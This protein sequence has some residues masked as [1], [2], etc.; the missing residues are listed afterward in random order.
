MRAGGEGRRAF[1]G[2]VAD[3]GVR[4]WRTTG[5]GG[6][7]GE[8]DFFGWEKKSLALGLLLWLFVGLSWL[9]SKSLNLGGGALCLVD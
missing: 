4:G 9:S 7:A 5:I 1:G 2:G 8:G 6:G 3:L